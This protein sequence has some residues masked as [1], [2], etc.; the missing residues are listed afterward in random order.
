MIH[1]CARG[2]RADEAFEWLECMEEAGIAPNAV[3]LSALINA[4]GR[5]GQL[6]GPRGAFRVLADMQR[7]GLTPNVITYTTLLDA[8]AKACELRWAVAVFREMLAKGVQPNDVTCHALFCGCLQQGAPHIRRTRTARLAYGHCTRTAHALH[9]HCTCTAHAHAHARAR[10]H[11]GELL[12]AREVLRHMASVGMRP[13]A[14]AF[15]SLLTLR[16]GSTSGGASA[17]AAACLLRQMVRPPPGAGEAAGEA[18]EAGEAAA[19]AALELENSLG[20]AFGNYPPQVEDPADVEWLDSMLA[21]QAPERWLSAADGVVPPPPPPPS[22]DMLLDSDS[23]LVERHRQLAMLDMLLAARLP[24]PAAA[25]ARVLGGV[26]TRH[27]LR[28]ARRRVER[29][30]SD[31][32]MPVHAATYAALLRAC[33]RVSRHHSNRAPQPPVDASAARLIPF[34]PPLPLRA[35]SGGRRAV[36]H[37]G[38]RADGR[39]RHLS[40]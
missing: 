40:L 20:A 17:A 8:C 10:A 33:A 4:C 23:S 24:P 9:M 32:L 35:L 3:T 7:A 36:C 11:A 2:A 6:T 18:D 12:L 1:V 30:R 37:R 26:G 13:T 29:A 21:R 27:D 34:S 22:L 31:G 19:A 14:H 38:P 39:G 25:W 28:E 16:S 15:T 5:A